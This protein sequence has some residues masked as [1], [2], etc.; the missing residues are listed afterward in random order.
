MRVS[1]LEANTPANAARVGNRE[2]ARL[3]GLGCEVKDISY[4]ESFWHC[5]LVTVSYEMP[6]EEQHG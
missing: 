2:A 6:R 1:I 5:F 3:E 4:K